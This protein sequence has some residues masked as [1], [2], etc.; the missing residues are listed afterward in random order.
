MNEAFSMTD[1]IWLVPTLPLVGFVVNTLLGRRLSRRWVGLV[2]CGTVG[3]AAALSLA[4][5]FH[6]TGL[7]E[8]QL[9]QE[10]F[11]WI[12]VGEFNVS[13]SFLLDPLSAVMILVVTWIGFLIHIYSVGYM[14]EDRNYSRFFAYL[15]LFA[16]GTLLVSLDRVLVRKARC[17]CGC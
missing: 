14:G 15:N 5:A 8:R 1:L 4:L 7:L 2:A 13:V 6:L 3:V 11:T 16:G 10:L 17:R 9:H 12:G